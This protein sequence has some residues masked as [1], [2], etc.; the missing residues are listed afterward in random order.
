[1]NIFDECSGITSI[2]EGG[3]KKVY[4]A[5]HPKYGYVALKTGTFSSTSSIER[6]KREVYFLRSIES[7]YFPKNFGF[8]IYEDKKEFLIV[9]E[10]IKSKNQNE[11]K[12]F[13]NSEKKLVGLLKELICALKIMWDKRIVHRDLKQDNILFTEEF[14][15][16]II[17]L[18][19][20]RFLDFDSLT[21]TI[22]GMGPCTPIYAAPEQLMNKKEFIDIRTDF[23]AIGIILLELH[24]GFHPYHPERVGNSQSISQNILANKFVKPF[25]KEGTSKEFSF[26]L[27]KLLKPQP[28]QRFR[29]YNLILEYIKSYWREE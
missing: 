27:I 2:F 10:F 6:I 11:V 14:K 4:K 21:Q 12:N 23:F 7:E 24:L 15:P 22:W 9:E 18:G 29:N 16:K 3:Q 1:M 26:L 8:E 5:K 17:D 13:F 19:I 28:Y 20:A 25:Y